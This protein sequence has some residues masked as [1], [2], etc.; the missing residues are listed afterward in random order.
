MKHPAETTDQ[1]RGNPASHR[2]REKIDATRSGDE[3]SRDDGEDER[4]CQKD[5]SDIG[6]EK[7]LQGILTQLWA[8]FASSTLP[9]DETK[10]RG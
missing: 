8:R 3:E 10:I 2:E 1:F 5:K 7:I 4:E 6:H 9:L